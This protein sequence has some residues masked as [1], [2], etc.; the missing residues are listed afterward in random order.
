MNKELIAQ[1]HK[2]FFDKTG[3]EIS[4]SIDRALRDI[5]EAQARKRVIMKKEEQGQKLV[6]K[7]AKELKIFYPICNKPKEIVIRLNT[8]K[9]WKIVLDE[10]NRSYKLL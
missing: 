7:L 10:K 4:V 8:K 1:T 6:K 5:L 3:I 2:I 9:G